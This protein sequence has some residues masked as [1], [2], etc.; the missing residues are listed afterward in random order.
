M[1]YAVLAGFAILGYLIGSINPAILISRARGLD[2]RQSGSKNA[3]ATNALRTMG[4]RA[5]ALVL[6]VDL[7]KGIIAVLIPMGFKA[8]PY[9]GADF[10][11]YMAGL[12]AILGH[13][14]PLYFGF[15]GGKG[16]LTSLGVIIYLFWPAGVVSLSVALLLI[17]LTRYVSLGSLVGAVLL[18]AAAFLTRAPEKY[19]LFSFAVSLLALLRHRENIKRLLNG[20]ER[21]IGEKKA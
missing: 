2:I 17:A 7:A 12:G 13:N 19:I 6:A 14:F 5:A 1:N 16:V 3:G 20:S 4:P 15:K 10:A 9:G 11:P 21:K 8:L 18:P